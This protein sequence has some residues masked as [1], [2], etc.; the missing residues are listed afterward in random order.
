MRHPWAHLLSY[1][2]FSYTIVGVSL[3]L[4]S[5]ARRMEREDCSWHMQD[6]KVV[7]YGR[8]S[9]L[10]QKKH[11]FGM[12]IQ[13]R[14]IA[15]YAAEHGWQI[16]TM[17]TD[18]AQSG[19]EEKRSALQQLLRD[20]KAGRIGALIIPSLDRLSRSLR[21][22]ENLFYQ[23]E[24]LGVTVCIV[25]MP[26]YDGRDRKEVLIR[27][28]HEVIA[29]DNRKEIIER[30]KKGREERVRKGQMS[31][32]NVAYGYRRQQ[33]RIQVVPEEAE[34]I[35]HI[36]ALHARGVKDHKIA[37]TLNAQRYYRRNGK[38][39]TQREVW[40]I[41]HRQALYTEGVITYGKVASKNEDL[42]LLREQ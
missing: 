15:R 29:E 42:I 32:G 28:I 38:P 39:W 12:A 7:G 1:S 6:K 17:Y 11:G 21:F 36:F 27:Q 24:Q 5:D 16:A 14:D 22:A 31:G 33:G 35:R 19:T 30:L 20:C 10:E 4:Q 41:V 23:F 3:S 40:T 26:H 18:E 34:I 9:T 2:S 37:D 13:V 25:D 8:V